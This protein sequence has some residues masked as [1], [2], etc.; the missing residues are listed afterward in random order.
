[1][2][3]R[4]ATSAD[5]LSLSS[6]SMDVQTLHAKQHPDIFKVPKSEDF[7]MSFFEEMLTDPFVRIFIAEQGG[8]ALGYI[9][10]RLVE[11]P[12]TP[13]TFAARLLHIDQISVRPAVQ[14]R[15]VGAAL[16]FRAEAVATDW[17]AERIQ[18]DSWDFN[19]SAHAFFEHLGFQ[20]FHYRFWRHLHGNEK[21]P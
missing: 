7:A 13:F 16:M 21:V 20:K 1:M 9:L 14:G 15:G 12:E 5:A 18:L 6:L 3:I 19:T 8:E 17:G 4:P 2:N 10:C 11:R